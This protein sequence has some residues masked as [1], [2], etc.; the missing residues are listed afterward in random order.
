MR[1]LGEREHL[2]PGASRPWTASGPG[3]NPILGCAAAGI[4]GVHAGPRDEHSWSLIPTGTEPGGSV[5]AG[6]QGGLIIAKVDD[7]SSLAG[8]MDSAQQRNQD[9]HLADV[10]AEAQKG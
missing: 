1:A 5:N 6:P 2:F 10:E 8:I 9:S 3:V 7:V 4:A